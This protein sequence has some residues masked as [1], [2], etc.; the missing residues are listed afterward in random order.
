[1][2]ARAI[3]GIDEQE[4]VGR[5]V[6]EAVAEDVEI[7]LAV[8]QEGDFAKDVVVRLAEESTAVEEVVGVSDHPRG[9]APVAEGAIGEAGAAQEA[10]H[11]SAATVA[12]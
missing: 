2:V 6:E 8:E 9:P 5:Q 10:A 11:G 12:A 4:S 7:A 3:D 1:M